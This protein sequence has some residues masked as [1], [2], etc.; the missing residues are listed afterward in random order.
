[1]PAVLQIFDR[2]AEDLGPGV[3]AADRRDAQVLQSARRGADDDDLSRELI[4][5]TRA[6]RAVE[7]LVEVAVRDTGKAAGAAAPGEHHVVLVRNAVAEVRGN[8]RGERRHAPAADHVAHEI[9]APDAVCIG[10]EADEPRAPLRPRQDER[11]NQAGARF[12]V[13]VALP[14]DAEVASQIGEAYAVGLALERQLEERKVGVAVLRD[15]L[16]ERGVVLAPEAVGLGEGDVEH[17][18]ARLLRRETLQQLGVHDARPG[19]APRIGLH[20]RQAFFVD[21]DEHDV[22]VGRELRRLRAH[23]AVE[24]P[25]LE[26]PEHLHAE[27][28]GARERQRREG[29]R[30]QHAAHRAAITSRRAWKRSTLASISSRLIDTLST[31]MPSGMSRA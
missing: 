20:A 14:C 17:D 27:E 1:M 31:L 13:G 5:R 7:I 29:E 11:R 4:G 21:V 3:Y 8:A 16:G 25:V 23:E 15:R 6:L 18:R 22:R 2:G 30:G 19:P 12:G 10:D 9:A 26:P 28:L 24:Q